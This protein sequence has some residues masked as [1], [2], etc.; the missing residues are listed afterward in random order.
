MSAAGST[1]V[2]D[3]DGKSARATRRAIPG[4]PAPERARRYSESS[5]PSRIISSRIDPT[6]TSALPPMRE[7]VPG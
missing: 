1:S 7:G 4:S 2:A 3:A 5:M 6:R